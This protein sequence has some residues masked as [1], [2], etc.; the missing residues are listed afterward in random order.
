MKE[1]GELSPKRKMTKTEKGMK[2]RHLSY[3]FRKN[4]KIIVARLKAIKI[5]V[6][7]IFTKKLFSNEAYLFGKEIF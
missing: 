3:L 5:T 2:F 4:I 1:L 6:N 7:D